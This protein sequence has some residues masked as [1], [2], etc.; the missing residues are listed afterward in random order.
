MY[1]FCKGD[2]NKFVL[3][4]R[5]GGYPNGDMDNWGKSDETT[6]PPKEHFY[7]ELNLEVLA[8]LI[9]STPKKYTKYLK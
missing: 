9:M 2:L 6:L 4:L 8:M 5:K 3:L 1:R 7:S